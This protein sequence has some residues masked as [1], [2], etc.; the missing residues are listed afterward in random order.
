[1][2]T[3]LLICMENTFWNISRDSNFMKSFKKSFMLYVESGKRKDMEAAIEKLRNEQGRWT[4][5]KDS[6]ER[7]CKIITEHY[8]CKFY[9]LHLIPTHLTSR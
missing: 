7:F 1:M 5:T 8:L 2:P 9:C 3:G 6:R 4:V